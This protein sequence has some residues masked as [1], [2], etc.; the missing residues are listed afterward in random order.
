MNEAKLNMGDARLP[1]PVVHTPLSTTRI[2]ITP[3]LK[4]LLHV[5]QLRQQDILRHGW[6]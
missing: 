2:C 6:I 4:H 3:V 5:E 1:V